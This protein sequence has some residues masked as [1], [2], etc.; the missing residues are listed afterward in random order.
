MSWRFRPIRAKSRNTPREGER[1]EA[2]E[3]R[4]WDP[5]VGLSLNPEYVLTPAPDARREFSQFQVRLD[6]ARPGWGG[7]FSWV[8]TSLEGNLDNVTGYSAPLE[9]VRP[10]TIRLGIVAYF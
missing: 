7:S 8:L 9:R 3:A 10:Q 2:L 1:F 4:G 5:R 6:L